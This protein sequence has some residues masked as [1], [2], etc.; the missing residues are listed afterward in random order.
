MRGEGIRVERT[1]EP[2]QPWELD[3]GGL[4]RET[5]LRINTSCL[6][7]R[8]EVEPAPTTRE[9]ISALYDLNLKAKKCLEARGVTVSEP[10]SREQW[11]EDFKSVEE[12]PW[13]PFDDPAAFAY[14]DECPDPDIY[15]V[16]GIDLYDTE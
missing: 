1:D 3:P 10:P 4:D 13:S 16:Y 2:G 9:E 11:I 8:P 7:Q 14:V 12:G 5:F 15:D 6:E